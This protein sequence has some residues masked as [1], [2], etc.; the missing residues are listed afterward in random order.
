MKTTG[1]CAKCAS[2]EILKIPGKVGAYGSGNNIPA[3]RTIFSS[4]KVTRYLCGHCGY[5]EEWVES[6]SD[7]QKLRERYKPALLGDA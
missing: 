6:A 5:C 1:K 4:V 2:T 3:G 7:L